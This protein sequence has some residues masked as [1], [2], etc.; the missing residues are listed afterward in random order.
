M[1]QWEYVVIDNR[2]IES[3][4]VMKGKHRDIKK[5]FASQGGCLVSLMPAFFGSDDREKRRILSAWELGRV[6]KDM[7]NLLGSGLSG[8]H[9]LRAI[10]DASGH[11][12]LRRACA[13]MGEQL[14]KGMSFEQ[15]F[16]SALIFPSVCVR[17]VG[18]GERAG[19]LSEVLGSM[20]DYFLFIAKVREELIG[21]FVYPLLVL[22]VL[23]GVLIYTSASIIPHLEVLL[24]SG[25]MSSILTRMMLRVGQA[26]VAHGWIILFIM[27]VLVVGGHVLFHS[28]REM[29]FLWFSRVPFFGVVRQE[30]ELT[31]CFHTL[32]VL[33]KSGLSIDLALQEAAMASGGTTAACLEECRAYLAGGLTLS[34]AFRRDPRMPRL[35]PDTLRLGEETGRFHEYFDR[36]YRFYD[37][38]FCSRVERSASLV[39]PGLLLFCGGLLGLF[40]LAFLQP[41]Y[42]S[43]S[44]I[45]IMG[46]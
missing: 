38:S 6:L 46:H 9:M 28:R 27:F 45:G 40:V 5:R 4:G 41:L 2:G 30:L 44:N 8:L 23:I 19:R 31:R 12:D 13:D 17:A 11:E 26:M 21:A 25:A 36:L 22:G 37:R 24:P 14:K 16:S 35:V 32:S 18:A 42:G 3:C 39:R 10:S 43:L 7:G 29:V 34:E 20:A 1:M 15:A 33:Q